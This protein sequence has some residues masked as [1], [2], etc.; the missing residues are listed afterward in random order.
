MNK[1]NFYNNNIIQTKFKTYL[2]LKINEF[3]LYEKNKSTLLLCNIRL[4]Y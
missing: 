2:T 3:I 1:V 4:N